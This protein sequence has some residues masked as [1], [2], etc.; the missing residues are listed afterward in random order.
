[1]NRKQAFEEMI[2]ALPSEPVV[3]SGRIPR[4]PLF[5]GLIQLDAHSNMTRRRVPVPVSSAGER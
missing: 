4:L 3:V 2:N 5:F 1:L